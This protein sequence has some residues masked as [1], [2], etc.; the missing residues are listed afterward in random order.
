VRLRAR[1]KAEWWGK[2]EE[3][4]RQG[5]GRAQAQAQARTQGQTQ[6]VARASCCDHTG[7]ACVGRR[8]GEAGPGVCAQVCQ[9]PHARRELLQVSVLVVLAQAVKLLG[10][11]D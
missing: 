5:Q 10:P 1:V 3:G 6:G 7:Q 4:P 9:A 2:G 11:L 8:R